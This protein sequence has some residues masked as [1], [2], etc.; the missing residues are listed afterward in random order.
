[1]A[2]APAAAQQCPADA[3]VSTVMAPGFSCALGDKTFSAFDI[4]GAPADTRIQ[5]GILQGELFAVTLARDGTFFP[6]GRL[7][8]DYT[9]TAAAGSHILGG[10][11][12]VDV[13]FPT[14]VTTTSMDSH[15]LGPITNGGTV[16]TAFSPGLTSVLV[17]N[18]ST[19]SGP[20]ELNSI[21]NDFAQVPIGV[22]EFGNWLQ[23]NG[24]LAMGLG[25]VFVL[26]RKGRK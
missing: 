1:M 26:N 24:L 17:D 14:V 6:D 21:T 16:V 13:S 3:Q 10:S 11:V 5:F 25:I 2:A 9:V 20:A 19:I 7:V 22:M 8:F 18:T 4:T 15:L 12:G 23:V